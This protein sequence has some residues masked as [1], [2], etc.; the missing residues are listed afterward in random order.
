MK[1]HF[2]FPLQNHNCMYM[3]ISLLINAKLA[4]A[5]HCSEKY[6]SK[7]HTTVLINRELLRRDFAV[8]GTV[9]F[10]FDAPYKFSGISKSLSG[11][12]ESQRR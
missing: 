7:L 12:S 8:S 2:K 3:H 5:Y 9:A 10:S 1:E 11:I 6:N 4:F